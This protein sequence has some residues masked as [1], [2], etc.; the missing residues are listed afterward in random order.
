MKKILSATT[1]VVQ[2]SLKIKGFIDSALHPVKSVRDFIKKIVIKS[3]VF[4]VKNAIN[5]VVKCKCD[6]N[7]MVR[8]L[9]AL[10]DSETDMKG[11][12]KNLQFKMTLDSFLEE[13]DVVEEYKLLKFINVT[14]LNNKI[15]NYKNDLRKDIY[16][17]ISEKNFEN[18][19]TIIDGVNE[20]LSSPTELI[21]CSFVKSEV[22]IESHDEENRNFSMIIN[23]NFA[24][25]AQNNKKPSIK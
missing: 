24:L 14:K 21:G 20:V 19:K 10:N 25:K 15:V 12:E 3:I 2:S 4:L 16:E 11:L 6:S 1:K 17:Y 22:I 7:I 13:A 18:L 8:Q 5:L 23:V 9:K